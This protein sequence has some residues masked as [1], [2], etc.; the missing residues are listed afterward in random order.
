MLFLISLRE[1]SGIFLTRDLVA[2]QTN[3]HIMHGFLGTPHNTFLTLCP[4]M[5]IIYERLASNLADQLF[6]GN[7]T[8]QVIFK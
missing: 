1:I 7:A 2:G 5:G 6:W 4:W 3:K 8:E